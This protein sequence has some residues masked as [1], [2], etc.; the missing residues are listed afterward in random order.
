MKKQAAFLFA[1]LALAAAAHAAPLNNGGFESGLVDWSIAGDAA[2]RGEYFGVSPAQGAWQL[3]LGTASASQPDDAPLAVATFNL[4]GAEPEATGFALET[5]VGL[6]PGGLDPDPANAIQ[7]YEGSAARQVFDAAAGSTLN[8]RY[9]LLTNETGTSAQGDYAFVVID[10]VMLKLANSSAATASW[11][12][13]GAQTG[14][15]NFSYTFA[16]GG[17]HTLALGVVD[18]GDYDRSSLL[19]VDAVTVSAVPEPSAWLLMA[20]GLG[21]LTLMRRRSRQS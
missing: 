10:G 1:T 19:A 7:A 13:S 11:N 15:G 17:S 9:N 8:L 2:V 5:F 14:I 4:S 6:A 16:T 3:L 18:V 21:A 12:G 20:F